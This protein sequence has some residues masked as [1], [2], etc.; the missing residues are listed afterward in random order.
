MRA[1]PAAG[2][3][4]GAGGLAA[5]G[6]AAPPSAALLSLAPP[7]A[8]SLGAAAATAVAVGGGGGGGGWGLRPLLAAAAA[9]LRSPPLASLLPQHPPPQPPPLTPLGADGRGGGGGVGGWGAPLGRGRGWPEGAGRRPLAGRS[10]SSAAAVAAPPPPPPSLVWRDTMTAGRPTDDAAAAAADGGRPWRGGRL[11]GPSVPLALPPAAS[12]ADDG[13][14]LP[15][16]SAS[17]GDLPTP[18]R[19][20]GGEGAASPRGDF[21]GLAG[22][23]ARVSWAGG[24]GGGSSGG[25]GG[26]GGTPS[27]S[28]HPPW[29]GG[30]DD[31]DGGGSP[32]RTATRGG[33]GGGGGGGSA[34]GGGSQRYMRLDSGEN[35]GGRGAD[36]SWSLLGGGDGSLREGDTSEG[37]GGAG[38]GAERRGGRG[39]RAALARC[40]R[41]L[42]P[43]PTM[44]PLTQADDDREAEQR[45]EEPVRVIPIGCASGAGART[46]AA[47]ATAAAAASALATAPP[48]APSNA[49]R[50]TKYT[51][52]SFLPR[53]LFEQFRLF[54]NAFFLGVA[55]TQ[56]IP[57]LRVG[58]FWAYFG[59]LAFVLAISLAKEARD[60]A[61]RARRDRAVNDAPY[62][63]L[64]PPEVAGGATA[65]PNDGDGGWAARRVAGGGSP[66]GRPVAETVP[67]RD[68]RVGD[69]L[70]LAMDQRVPADCLLL[71][72]EPREAAAATASSAAA[73]MGEGALLPAA[74]ARVS[75]AVSHGT[76]DGAPVD[77]TGDA[78]GGSGAAPTPAT[79]AID[80][81]DDGANTLF[82]RTDQLDGETDWKLRRAAHTSQR[83]GSDAAVLA[84]GLL[85][86]A[87][88]P[89]RALDSFVG[90]LDA[91][92]P[93]G[94]GP[95]PPPESLAVDNMLWA[96]TVVASGRA[97][98]LVVYIGS[99]SRA[100]RN[101]SAARSKVGQ[102]D[103]EVNRV[104]KLLFLLLVSLSLML[105]ALR[106]RGGSPWLYAFRY[107][108]L[109]SSIIPVSLRINLDMAKLVYA[110][111]VE[112]DVELG[113]G[114]PDAAAVR[115][116]NCP[117]ELGRV[118]FLLTDKTGTLTRNEMAFKKLHLGAVLFSDDALGDVREYLRAACALP[119]PC[120]VMDDGLFPPPPPPVDSFVGGLGIGAGLGPPLANFGGASSG[121][122]ARR[123]S[124][125][126][127]DR[128]IEVRLRDAVLAIAL[129][130]NVTP[131]D[132]VDVG[133]GGESGGGG[134]DE[135]VDSLP[136]ARV[137][138]DTTTAPSPRR[139][140]QA[141][142]PDEVALVRF[143]ESVGVVLVARTSRSV[144][145]SVCGAPPETWSLVAEFPFTSAAKRSAVVVR[146]VPTGE[147]SLYVKGADVAVAPLVNPTDWLDEEC[148][149]MAR[150]GLRT[151]VYARR[152]LGEADLAGLAADLAAARQAVTAADRSAA[153]ATAQ[154]RLEVGL[155]VVALTGVEDRLAPGVRDALE[156]LRH[157]GVRTWMLTGDKVE[158]ATC[159]AVSARLIARG[160]GLFAL[161]GLA[162]ADGSA[163]A[164]AAAADDAAR[165]LDSFRSLR[166]R[167][168]LVVDGDALSVLL[169]DPALR[170]TFIAAAVDAPAAV[171]CRCSPAQKA[172][173]VTALQAHSGKRVA[174]IGDGGNDVGMIT[175]ADV[176]IG[177]PGK[178]GRQAALAADVSV[179][180]FRHLPRL[181]LWHGRNAY[182]RSA[183]LAQFVIHR[184]LIISV[185][186]TV[187]CALF[188]YA[189]ISVYNGW[190]LVGY[191]TVFTSLPVFT[192]VLDEDVSS[193]AALTYPEL[194]QELQKG[195]ALNLRTFLVW[196]AKSIYQG[197]AIMVLSVYVLWDDEFFTTRHLAAISFTA[198]VLTEWLMVAVELHALRWYTVVAIASSVGAYAAA[199]ALLPDS[200][201][202]PMMLTWGFLGRVVVVTLVSCVPVTV[203]KWL[204]RRFAPAAY[205]K[206]A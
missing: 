165:A 185:I 136:E 78:R 161:T 206:I 69:V 123:S 13:G 94:D 129:A 197:T 30:S 154:R 156:R 79:A 59:P 75:G 32:W 159:V 26:G 52:F 84:A 33:K 138:L 125:S 177:I 27:T 111:M 135:L 124:W 23:G 96:N 175:A 4:G 182:T 57:A 35:G 164:A 133:V 100:V 193:A 144:V 17:P 172:A 187:Y 55:L 157:A 42:W 114:T 95:T 160:A 74:A 143:A 98:V 190:I 155:T 201:D 183:R 137:E 102:L 97:T 104:S 147:T 150:E 127:G 9:G 151:L 163:A 149:N 113:A 169:S 128:R 198:L 29:G 63:R 178:E 92:S 103:V 184:G 47:A 99:D 20:G 85:L 126:G 115:A 88:P 86:H 189:A 39:W 173:L 168:G 56:F 174:A 134:G 108:L 48:P 77:E 41:V 153:V 142:S 64:R 171:A 148:G 65:A 93:G 36:S 22:G 202:A 112:G 87:E 21:G 116:S 60:D 195:R 51:P 162:P 101:A 73:P 141:A 145:L 62:T 67:S 3:R 38:G 192:I 68:I 196:V 82:I 49:V 12:P 44:L 110:A 61:A 119:E 186:Q 166:G 105:T 91:P 28:P 139:D 66:R 14:G 122:G 107:F 118:G 80:D 109:L 203:G 10:V 50:N 120:G 43:A 204:K 146:H 140:F 188:F 19:R 200:F 7:G 72:A 53:V 158:T 131:V 179:A 5:A 76:V 205:S 34:G 11:G 15:Y 1:R 121:S 90:R 176:G 194:Y 170:D 46:T 89:K 71:R 45:E 24:S 6:A 8:S 199:V 70:V 191:A 37:G 181:L 40:R 132:A 81:E 83:L 106:G 18:P 130:H 54:Y 31:G 180:L 25:G 2:G 167:Y 152:V 58:F 117:E 16:F